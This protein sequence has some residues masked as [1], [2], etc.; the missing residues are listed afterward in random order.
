MP[1][2][3]VSPS[4]R[5]LSGPDWRGPCRIATRCDRA[6]QRYTCRPTPLR[7]GENRAAVGLNRDAAVALPRGIAPPGIARFD[8]KR[9]SF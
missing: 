3:S 5:I 9:F 6:R 8:S 2:R 7:Y 4:A 1:D